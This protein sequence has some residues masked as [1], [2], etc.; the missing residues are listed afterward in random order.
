[1][2]PF[3]PLITGLAL[4]ATLQSTAQE[5][6]IDPAQ[7]DPNAICLGLWAPVCG[8]DNMTYSN[9]CVAYYSGV[10]SWTAGECGTVTA[11]PCTDLA[12][13]DLGACD[14]LLGVAV[15][16]GVCQ[17]V[18][19]CGTVSG[20]TDYAPAIYPDMPT[21][22]ACLAVDAEPCTDLATVDF[23][24]CAMALGIGIVNN[25]CVYISGCGSVVDG[26]DY[27]PALYQ[28]MGECEACVT[29]MGEL[30][31]GPAAYPNPTADR[32]TVALGHTLA[33]LHISDLTGR[34]LWSQ[35]GATGHVVIDAQPLRS[36]TYVLHLSSVGRTGQMR[37]VRE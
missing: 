9:D 19:G 15:V 14:M 13:V 31:W 37:V 11:E 21:C 12:G 25:Q 32:W 6:C 34:V 17:S 29:G 27:T 10:T 8:C 22:Q 4:S 35:R 3:T 26:V 33:D 16:N 2:R 20:T 1:M 23:G 30:T 7:I 24:M 18:S 28:S 36:G 5:G